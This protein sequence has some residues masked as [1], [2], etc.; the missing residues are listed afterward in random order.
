MAERTLLV[1]EDDASLRETMMYTLRREGY[2]VLVAADGV[3]A[4]EV[5]RQQPPGDGADT[6]SDADR[7]WRGERC[8]RRAGDRRRRLRHQAV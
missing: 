5:A 2:R 1:V 6:D 4:L 3:A 8:R 7:A